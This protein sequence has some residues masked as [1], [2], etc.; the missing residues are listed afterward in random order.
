MGKKTRKKG[1][2]GQNNVSLSGS[3][4]TIEESLSQKNH[5]DEVGRMLCEHNRD[6]CHICCVDHRL[7]NRSIEEGAGLKKK[8]TELEN[9]ARMYATMLRAL[10]GMERMDPLP[11]E[12]VFEQN[13]HRRDIFRGK[14]D[15]F[16]EAEEDVQSVIKRAIDKENS[17]ELDM[18]AK[19]QSMSLLNPGQTKFELGGE[20]SQTIYDEFVKGPQGKETRADYYTCSY[21]GKTGT[22]KLQQ[23]SRCK[24]ASYCSRECQSAAWPAHKKDDCVKSEKEAKN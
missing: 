5:T 24:K 21:C 16:A 1:G 3:I 11:S 10:R 13:R 15:R 6:Y 20:E 7:G 2:G 9:V 22:I 23:C 12:E 14:L 18:Q 8:E 4:P 17:D 19:M